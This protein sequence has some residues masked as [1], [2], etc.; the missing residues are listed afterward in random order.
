MK[1]QIALACVAG[2]LIAGGACSDDEDDDGGAMAM[3]GNAG[4]GGMMAM[5]GN[6]G[7]G[8]AGMT[9]V[10][11]LAGIRGPQNPPPLPG[12]T[13]IDRAGRVAVTAALYGAFQA[14]DD[15]ADLRDEYNEGGLGGDY[16][17]VIAT[18]LGI[19]DGLD[20]RCGN[21]LL[22]GAAP[23]GRY[24]ALAGVLADDQL[25]VNSDR[26]NCQPGAYLGVEAEV[27][28]ALP[29]GDGSCGGR[30]P[31]DDVV[32]RSYSVLAAGVLGGVDD[33]VPSD[34]ATHDPDTFPFLAAPS[35]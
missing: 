1:K 18:S 26:T 19:L 10:G 13:R 6:A 11:N 21:Q 12:G 2:L 32:E 16:V 35:P 24:D 14:P 33:G 7:S 29:E 8:G 17:D 15:A 27:V 30:I 28:G 20:A 3:A 25:Y 23:S 31:G 34:D 4:M 22:A 5:A 9:G